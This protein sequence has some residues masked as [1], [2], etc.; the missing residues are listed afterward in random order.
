MAY[1]LYPYIKD[2]IVGS[3]FG[4]MIRSIVQT[5]YV[6]PKIASETLTATALPEYMRSMVA[7]GQTALNDALTSFITN[8]VLNLISFL[9]VFIITRILISIIGKVVNI[10]SRL[11]VIRFFDRAVGVVFGIIEGVIIIYLV[12][13]LVYAITPLRENENTQK[14]ISESTLTKAM[15]EN[16]PIVQLV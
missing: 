12:L 4:D 14:Y 6:E 8:L 5:K 9:S 2:F 3:A 7:T 13:A 15:Y 16:N 11:P 10:V 1:I